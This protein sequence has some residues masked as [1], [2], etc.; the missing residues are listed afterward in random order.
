MQVAA[1]PTRPAAD[2]LGEKLRN[3]G[4][5]VRVWGTAPPFRVR[6]GRF[7]TEAQANAELRELKSKGFVG[8]VTA[9]E[10]EEG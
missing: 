8:F 1:Y 4:Y 2:A 10:P 7:A 9:A 5:P 3:V 6:I